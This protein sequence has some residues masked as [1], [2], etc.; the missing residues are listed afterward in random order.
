MKKCIKVTIDGPSA[1]GK[2]T[3]AKKLA[4]KLSYMHL[5]TGAIYRAI[6][7]HFKELNVLDASDDKLKVALSSFSYH[8]TGYDENKRHYLNDRDIT[9]ELRCREISDLSSIIS[10][11]V[12]VRS[13]ATD[14]QRSFAE[15]FNVVVEGRDTGSVV[16]PDADI[17][18]YLD[19]DPIERAKRRFSE[20]KAKHGYQDLTKEEIDADLKERDN[21]DLKR[22]LSPLVC[23]EGALKVDTTSLTVSQIV[24]KLT[25]EVK[26]KAPLRFAS[27]TYYCSYKGKKCSFMYL[28]TKWVFGAYFK[29]FHTYKVE[30]L[31][32]FKNDCPAIIACNHVSFLDPPMLGCASPEVIHC[33]AKRA[34]YKSRFMSWWL[35]KIN[36]Y[37]VSG[38]SDDKTVMK[39]VLA[40][41]LKGEK[42]LIFPEGTR[43]KDG[44]VQPLRKGL[45]LF[46][47]KGKAKVIP[48]AVIGPEHALPVNKKF[49]KLFTKLTVAFGPPVYY[50]EILKE[51]KDKKKAREIFLERVQNE[52]QSLIDK[53]KN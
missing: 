8:F 39:K 23:P 5:D 32:N 17:K 7:L 53:Y 49:P 12:V 25:Y 48:A 4:K 31:E 38:A 51:V 36:T 24:A 22:E 14:L 29:I 10:T 26:K 13:F 16:F 40:L 15:Q 52:I 35:H 1:S 37:P 33:L 47:D 46:A 42:V 11:N 18:F 43:G 27:P 34:L 28:L 45:A 44:T 6:A 3:V 21:R 20:L 30:G 9:Q 2:S 19:A 41:L 50:R